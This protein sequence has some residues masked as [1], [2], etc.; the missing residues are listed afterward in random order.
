MFRRRLDYGYAFETALRDFYEAHGLR[1]PVAGI[2]GE[3]FEEC[4]SIPPPV[5]SNA[6]TGI[7]PRT[8]PPRSVIVQRSS[9]SDDGPENVIPERPAAARAG[10]KRTLGEREIFVGGLPLD[11][12]E[13][14]L[15]VFFS[16]WGT[17]EGC[18]VM[19]DRETGA[20]RGFGFVRFQTEREARV[21]K[22][23]GRAR[24][25]DGTRVV[26]RDVSLTRTR[27]VADAPTSPTAPNATG[28]SEEERSIGICSVSPGDSSD[29][30]AAAKVHE[31]EG[32]TKPSSGAG[33]PGAAS[34]ASTADT[35]DTV[36]TVDTDEP[37]GLETGFRKAH[38]SPESPKKRSVS[39]QTI[40][41]RR[42]L[43]PRGV[44]PP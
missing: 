5:V 33:T 41:R 3:H 25:P 31:K 7:A 2:G 11:T 29:S 37:I 34:S 21:V 9:A 27:G 35:V 13:G 18:R 38:R 8:P 42:G 39:P 40:L 17:V 10:E 23:L 32:P 22:R 6:S 15:E 20:S 28:D 24:F 36:D 19:Y 44:D 4:I 1:A 14:D 16:R 26:I 12:R 30:S 43:D